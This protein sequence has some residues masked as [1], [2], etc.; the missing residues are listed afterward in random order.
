MKVQRGWLFLIC[1]LV[2]I[3]SPAFGQGFSSGEFEDDAPAELVTASSFLSISSTSAGNTYR[4]ATVV[5]IASGWHINSSNPPED[6]LIAADLEFGQVEGITASNVKYPP[7]HIAFLGPIEMSV[8]DD[9]AIVY[10]DITIATGTASGQYSL[11]IKF[12]YQPCDDK[13]CR[14]PDFVS[15]PL[16]IDV[17]EEGQP[18]KASLFSIPVSEKSSD[19][20]SEASATTT[21][22]PEQKSDLELLIEKHGFWG[23]LMALGVAFVTGLLLSFSPCTY[24]M[25]PITVSIFAGQDR[26]IGRGFFLS[27]VYVGTMAFIYGLMGLVVAL[28]GGVFGAWLAN[29]A[30]VIGIAIV[31]VIFA[32]SMFGLYELNV[33]ASIRQKLGTA[34]STG[35]IV[36]AMILGVV[37]AL[38]VSPCVGPFVAGILLYV[39]TSGSPLFGFIILFVFAMGLGT[40]YILIATFSSTLTALPGAGEW[41]DT[42][43]KFFGFVLL[44]MA[45]Y[46]LQTVVP[47]DTI[48]LLTG[49]VLLALA[50]FGGGFDRLVPDSGFFLRL[51][52]FI[53]VLAFLVSIYLILGTILG[54]GLILPPASEWMP[55]GGSARAINQ[56]HIA[57][58]TD[59]EAGLD[60]AISEN[61]PVIIDTWA[62]WCANCKVLEKKTFGN[63]TVIAESKRFVALKIQL[64]TASSPES[65]AFMKR[66]GIRHYSLPT[67]LLLNSKGEIADMIQG[68][69]EPEDLVNRMKK[70]N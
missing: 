6:W 23:Y 47:A 16:K 43:K 45:L 33:P 32:M 48:A 52:K 67:T 2:L 69:I 17:G 58:Q 11:P 3:Q 30:V 1:V 55:S 15:A 31:F 7:G 68:V 9:S 22:L 21:S 10:F 42:I 62:T 28:V 59:L 66:F 14:A 61:K 49:L 35:G 4:A 20:Q 46:F 63:A 27:L 44:I 13:E 51:K 41:M 5:K 70:L 50:V 29:P 56:Q 19:D 38:V 18:V 65:V 53:G 39:A 64:E 60:R 40:L 12:T 26:K 54:T 8:Y 24:P 34:K 57:W 36:G 25:I 37:A